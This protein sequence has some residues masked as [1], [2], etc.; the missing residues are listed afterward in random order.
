MMRWEERAGFSAWRNL[1]FNTINKIDV[2]VWHCESVLGP[3]QRVSAEVA[4]K[5]LTIWGAWQHFEEDR[6]HHGSPDHQRRKCRIY[7]ITIADFKK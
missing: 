4:L 7:K 2:P 6:R 5:A 3:E 1:S